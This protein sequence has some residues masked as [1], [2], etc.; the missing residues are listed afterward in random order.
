MVGWTWSVCVPM[1]TSS[2]AWADH[3]YYAVY[4]GVLTPIRLV[5][6]VQHVDSHRQAGKIAAS[7]YVMNSTASAAMISPI[8]WVKTRIPLRPISGPTASA[9]L[10]TTTV[11]AATATMAAQMS[12]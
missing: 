1:S 5:D 8:T 4:T 10:S 9:S 11:L 12:T 3:R 2:P 7:P 6:R